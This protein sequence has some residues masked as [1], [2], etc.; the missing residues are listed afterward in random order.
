M[1]RSVLRSPHILSCNPP[2]RSLTRDQVARKQEKAIDFLVNVVGD[3]EVGQTGKTGLELADD[4]RD[5]SVEAY[6]DR[7]GIT[8][9]NPGDHQ[10]IEQALDKYL[11]LTAPLQDRRRAIEVAREALE[12]LSAT[13]GEAESVETVCEAVSGIAEELREQERQEE[14]RQRRKQELELAR[15]KRHALLEYGKQRIEPYLLRLRQQGEIG[16][17]EWLDPDPE[18]FEEVEAGLREE[19]TGKESYE[20]VQQLAEKLVDRCLLDFDDEEEEQDEDDDG[21]QEG[22][23]EDDYYEGEEESLKIR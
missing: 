16:K 2:K 13:A 9:Q 5:L 19:L 1:A 11:P 8:L 12:E 17:E 20:E 21:D 14:E 18:L 15:T 7:K 22:D 10:L 3:D 4:I 6:A 23:E